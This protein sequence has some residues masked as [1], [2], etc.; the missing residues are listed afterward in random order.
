MKREG[1]TR[2]NLVVSN[3]MLRALK[4]T[5]RRDKRTYSSIMREALADYL[6]I[7]DQVILGGNFESR[8]DTEGQQVG[9]GAD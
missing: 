7:P 4:A 5:A 1:T 9:A 3:T 6:G 2:I 8:D